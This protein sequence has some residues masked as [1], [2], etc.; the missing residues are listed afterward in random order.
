[1]FSRAQHENILTLH[2]VHAEMYNA[3]QGLISNLQH[4]AHM[5]CSYIAAENCMWTFR[6]TKVIANVRQTEHIFHAACSAQCSCKWQFSM[7]V[8][9]YM[10]VQQTNSSGYCLQP[11]AT[12]HTEATTE[13]HQ[14]NLSH[15]SS[16]IDFKQDIIVTKD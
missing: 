1:M 11:V 6:F 16:H 3:L 12:T 7:P 14:N 2:T 5:C 8:T 4:T 15:S 10:T 9:L 13:A